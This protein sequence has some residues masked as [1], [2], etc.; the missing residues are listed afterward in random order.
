[1]SKCSGNIKSLIRRMPKNK[2]AAA[3]KERAARCG[4]VVQVKFGWLVQMVVLLFST[5]F[6]LEEREE[7]THT[8]NKSPLMS[9][10]HASG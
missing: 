7:V 5:P 6:L 9:P 3:G 1:M 2:R 4:A 10:G 8:M